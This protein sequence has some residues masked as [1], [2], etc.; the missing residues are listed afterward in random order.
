MKIQKINKDIKKINPTIEL[1]KLKI[2]LARVLKII[3]A[4]ADWAK[5]SIK[6]LRFIILKTF[7]RKNF[8]SDLETIIY[9]K[10]EEP[11]KISRLKKS[12]R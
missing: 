9:K 1:G 7:E 2:I 4:M 8:L 11:M 10:I 12:P 5:L 6:D 3:N